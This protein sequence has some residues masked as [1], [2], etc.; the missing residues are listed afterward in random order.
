MAI[1]QAWQ[2][3]DTYAVLPVVQ[4]GFGPTAARTPAL[5]PDRRLAHIGQGAA[6]STAA[7]NS[8]VRAIAA[9]TAAQRNQIIAFHS[10]VGCTRAIRSAVGRRL[11]PMQSCGR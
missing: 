4:T 3:G 6:R 11:P 7:P 1:Q 10:P 9:P 2:P 8:E 5:R